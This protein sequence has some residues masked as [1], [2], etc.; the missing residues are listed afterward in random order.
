MDLVQSDAG[1]STDIKPVL[2]FRMSPHSVPEISKVE[3]LAECSLDHPFFVKDKGWCSARP[4]QTLERYGIPCGDLATGDICLPPNH[5]EAVKTP[6]LCDRFKRFEFSSAELAEQL[7][8]GGPRTSLCGPL[9]HGIAS[10]IRG[11]G[12]IMSP[13]MSPA[14]VHKKAVD[15]D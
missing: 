15:P 3:M 9:R 6:D 11:G 12:S 14:K 2:R 1:I 7:S 13:P 4:R 8:P 10:L 5:P